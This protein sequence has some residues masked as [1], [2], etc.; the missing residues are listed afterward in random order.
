MPRSRQLLPA[1]RP[2]LTL[3]EA[4][5]ELQRLAL[6][7]KNHMDE[8]YVARCSVQDLPKTIAGLS[9]RVADLTADKDTASEHA[10]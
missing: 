8:Q 7:K 1:T 6:L 5:A 4:E 10:D 2:I 9:G 3:A